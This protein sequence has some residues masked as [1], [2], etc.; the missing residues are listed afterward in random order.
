MQTRLS[1][2]PLGMPPVLAT[3]VAALAIILGILVI[4]HPA[5]LTWLVGIGLVLG[6]VALLASV[7]LASGRSPL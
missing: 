2:L 4:V 3:V 1:D 6:G 5:L 7:W